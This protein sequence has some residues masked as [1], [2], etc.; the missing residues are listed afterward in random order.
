EYTGIAPK[1]ANCNMHHSPESPCHACFNCNHLGHL[2]KD[3]RVVHRMVNLVNARNP[4][5]AHGACF[6]YGGTN[7]FK[8][9][10]P[11]LNQAQRLG[12]T[13]QTKLQLIIGD[14]IVGT[15]ETRHVEGHLCWEQRRLARTQTS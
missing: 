8:A 1:C 3:C 6:E 15:T 13:V 9:A 14:K 10:Y 2:A 11:R 5:A 7:H 12:E 4:I